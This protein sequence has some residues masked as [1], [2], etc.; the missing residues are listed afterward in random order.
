MIIR[1]SAQSGRRQ[2]SK[3]RVFE[4]PNYEIVF[5]TSLLNGEIESEL[6]Q[7][8]DRIVNRV[9]NATE[10]TQVTVI[11]DSSDF[12]LDTGDPTKIAV[13][14]GSELSSLKAGRA[15]IL[16]RNSR[17]IVVEKIP[18]SLQVTGGQVSRVRVGYVAGTRAAVSSSLMRQAIA[19]A[20]PQTQLK[21][22]LPDG[23][24]DPNSWAA[25]FDFSCLS[26]ATRRPCTAI[27]PQHVISAKHFPA[28]GR[29]AFSLPGGATVFRDI[30]SR[31]DVGD[32]SC[33]FQI[34]LLDSP[35]PPEVAIPKLV[36][37][38]LFNHLLTDYPVISTN[39]FGEALFKIADASA[40]RQTIRNSTLEDEALFG[41]DIVTFDSGFPTFLPTEDGLVFLTTWWTPI[42]GS[43]S[44]RF[45]SEIMDAIQLAENSHG[46][47][48]GLLPLVAD[49]S[50]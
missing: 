45:R 17:G 32:S 20:D 23:R 1:R 15:S 29:H 25:A 36:P 41:K 39:Q 22:R 31:Q 33:D 6:I 13:R 12:T 28:V 43:S 9:R 42:S 5:G 10:I 18:I 11:L 24:R 37:L 21:F 16:I 7:E 34:G 50:V 44:I 27:T 26:T 46:T 38:D 8:L 19:N 2:I 48:T 40:T 14:N 49:L 3:S 47:V 35:L 4:S 30:V